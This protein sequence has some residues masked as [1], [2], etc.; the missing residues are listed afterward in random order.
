MKKTIVLYYSKTGNNQFVAKKLAK[1]I[2]A[3]L[4]Q[5]ETKTKSFFSL[6]LLTWFKKGA[7]IIPLD[8]DLTTYDRVILLGPIWMGNLISPLRGFVKRYE[9]DI[10]D[11]VFI[12]VCGGG[13]EDKDSKYG[14]ENVFNEMR[15]LYPSP[16]ITCY[17][18][19]TKGVGGESTA[20][21]GGASAEC[22]CS[23][24]SSGCTCGDSSPEC[25]CSETS[26]GTTSVGSPTDLPLLTEELFHGDVK[27]RFDEVVE[28]LKE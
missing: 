4:E 15:K 8:I 3:D 24:S 7:K 1:E 19:S 9:K 11:F 23:G 17:E 20:V 13:D 27:D 18:I 16:A 21:G 28:A 6:I 10:Q 26:S 25:T 2:Q 5:I 14:F 12:T 22:A